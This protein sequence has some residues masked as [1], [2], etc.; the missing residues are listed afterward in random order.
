MR[1]NHGKTL[2]AKLIAASGLLVLALVSAVLAEGFRDVVV[3]GELIDVSCYAT[4]GDRGEAHRDCGRACLKL[5]DPVGVLDGEGKY[6]V[7]LDGSVQYVDYMAR[8]VRVTGKV[9]D[10]LLVPTKVEVLGDADQ[11]KVVPIKH[12]HH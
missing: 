12:L 6:Y 7:L 9:R 8:T 10:N 3:E 4:E 5:G 11:W 2:L 1:W